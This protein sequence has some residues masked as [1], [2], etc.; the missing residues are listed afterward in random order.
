MIAALWKLI[1]GISGAIRMAVA[2]VVVG[3]VT[4]SIGHS[5]GVSAGRTQYALELQAARSA[6]ETERNKDDAKRSALSD[7]DLCVQSLRS[8]G[9]PI[10]ACAAGLQ[11]LPG[12]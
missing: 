2:A 5:A 10:D 12:E 7:Y 6:V 9:M 8:R 11:R 1:G 4:Y 3:A